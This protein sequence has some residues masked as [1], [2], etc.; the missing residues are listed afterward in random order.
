[1]E[2]TRLTIEGAVSFNDI[3]SKY[4]TTS[5]IIPNNYQREYKWSISRN[6]YG[7]VLE[8]CLEDLY[9]A[10]QKEK[11]YLFPQRVGISESRFPH[12]FHLVDGQ[13]RLTTMF[14][15]LIVAG[16]MLPN[17]FEEDRFRHIFLSD[18]SLWLKQSDPDY[19]EQFQDSILG[20]T[21]ESLYN[22]RK[23]KELIAKYI[24]K[25]N[26]D[27]NRWVDYVLF[28]VGFDIFQLTDENEASYF[29][30]VN[31]KGLTL[32]DADALKI[33]IIKNCPDC[34][35][36]WLLFSSE[37]NIFRENNP[38]APHIRSNLEETLLRHAIYL[39]DITPYLSPGTVLNCPKLP[40]FNGIKWITT[41]IDYVKFLNNL[42]DP[43]VQI[44]CFAKNINIVAMYC[45]LVMV[46]GMDKLQAFKRC[47]QYLFSDPIKNGGDAE[48]VS[49]EI[50]KAK[51]I[52][53]AKNDKRFMYGKGKSVLKLALM[54]IEAY[55]RDGD[56]IDNLSHLVKNN[57]AVTLE[58]IR[59]QQFDGS[60][61]FGNLTFLTKP[62][63]SKLNGVQN[64][65]E[66]YK[67][68]PYLITRYLVDSVGI[69]DDRLQHLRFNYIPGMS[70]QAIASF[71]VQ[72]IEDRHDKLVELLNII[73][74]ND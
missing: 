66:I 57:K 62:E 45:K 8:I 21:D 36:Q 58:H 40:N 2:V 24:Q 64:K 26:S 52:V 28:N 10:M 25:T 29:E 55:F 60:D 39:S 38:I 30:D 72:D 4:S 31:T 41:A 15:I 50:D 33:Q 6:K 51:K 69:N 54:C 18:G 20:D 19:N 49:K 17:K 53:I 27:P 16:E 68:S 70:E 12:Q 14:L 59:S 67:N 73:L 5:L 46:K 44:L 37:I 42:D 74:E 43:Y 13:Q 23:A 1:M 61:L 22:I 48:G 56:W 7:N 35:K 63:N 47:L 65:S 32:G 34:E 71:S 3:L 9:A 11:D